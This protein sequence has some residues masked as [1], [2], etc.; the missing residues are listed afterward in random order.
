MNLRRVPDTYESEKY[1]PT[2]LFS[3]PV[4][5]SVCIRH[6]PPSS[7]RKRHTTCPIAKGAGVGAVS[8]CRSRRRKHPSMP[9]S[10]PESAPDSVPESAP[11]SV[12]GLVPESAPDSV[13][14]LAQVTAPPKKQID[15]CQMAKQKSRCMPNGCDRCH[16]DTCKRIF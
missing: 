3:F 10:V 15:L 2:V 11:E 13:P 14:A 7:E 9:K 1:A 4:L 6:P 16:T 12:L 8:R 5:S